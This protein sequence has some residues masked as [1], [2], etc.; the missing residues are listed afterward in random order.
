MHN[1]ETACG[2]LQFNTPPLNRGTRGSGSPEETGL[3]QSL[4]APRRRTDHALT[5]LLNALRPSRS[6]HLST[7]LKV[8]CHI[9]VH[10]GCTPD[11][12]SPYTWLHK[13]L[14]EHPPFNYRRVFPSFAA[15]PSSSSQT[16][17]KME[18][19]VSQLLQHGG[20]MCLFPLMMP[21]LAKR[22]QEHRHASSDQMFSFGVNDLCVCT[23]ACVGEIL[24]PSLG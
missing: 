13:P 21:D 16:Q 24:T 17:K 22:A 23:C 14:R 5:A 18:P 10:S 9:P 20:K 3:I 4:W 8:C 12:L 11:S 7:A 1:H 15:Q 6:P 19:L 2:I